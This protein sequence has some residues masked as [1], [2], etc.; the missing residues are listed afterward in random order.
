[1]APVRNSIRDAALRTLR[2]CG[3]FELVKN[4]RWRQQRLLIICYHGIALE[5]EHL[6]RPYL[7]ISP[8]QFERR[9]E[10]LRNGNYSVLRLGDAVE[11]MYKGELPPRSVALTFDDGTYDFY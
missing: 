9:L 4:S 6:W 10:I 8:R 2:S 1:M 7:F 5:D 3:L 11:K